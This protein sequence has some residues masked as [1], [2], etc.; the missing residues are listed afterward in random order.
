[1]KEVGI[2]IGL[3]HQE[4]GF[5]LGLLIDTWVS[6]GEVGIPIGLVHKELGWT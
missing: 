2:P 5:P 6:Q 1:M 3:V 4:L